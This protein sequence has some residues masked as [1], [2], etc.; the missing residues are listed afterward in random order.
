MENVGQN[1][2]IENQM[3]VRTNIWNSCKCEHITIKAFMLFRGS[4]LLGNV[5]VKAYIKMLTFANVG[6]YIGLLANVGAWVSGY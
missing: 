6:N 5:K 3:L 1:S 4:D 2:M